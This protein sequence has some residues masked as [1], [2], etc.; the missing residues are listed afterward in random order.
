MSKILIV[1]DD[2]EL[3]DAL[4]DTLSLLNYTTST[5]SNCKQAL[6]ILEEEDIDLVISDIQMK[7]MD[8]I[9]LLKQI[10]QTY[11]NTP[12]IMMTAY[13]TIK[14]AVDVLHLGALDYLVKPFEP[15]VLISKVSELLPQQQI[16]S[17]FVAV[18]E[19]TNEVLKVARK[20]SD[21]DAN[22]LV[23]GPS[24]AGK[25]VL[26]QY[27][28]QHSA[29]KENPF[30]AINCAAIPDNMLEAILFGYCKGAFT[31]AYKSSP[32]KFELAQGGTLLLDEISEMSLPLQAKILR[33]LQECE[34]ERLGE[35]KPITLDVRV[36][37]T[38]NRDLLGEVKEGRFR[39][40]LYYR[41]NVI[42]LTL[43]AL[44][45]RKNDIIPLAEFLLN[46][47]ALGSNVK[48]PVLTQS[49][50]N[51]LMAYHWPGNVREL[52]NIIQRA[53]IMHKNGEIE[54]EDILYEDIHDRV[55][56]IIEI[57]ELLPTENLK[58]K[59]KE[60]II[61]A[62]KKNQGSRK[63]TAKKLGI[64]PRTLRYKL[65]RMKEEGISIPATT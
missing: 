34:V 19:K 14:Q 2:L 62:L 20:I 3:Q 27:I 5:A 29:R 64:S 65:A 30:I 42:R 49:A 59:E 63:D 48:P 50:C 46:K 15:E 39:E 61:E 51:K 25:E 38:S 21:T 13:G 16:D 56:E 58:A 1:E 55:T 23:T 22:V 18:D 53:F 24:G 41:L 31:G 28:H 8:G 12:I 9:E 57:E 10:N 43:P 45:D 54:A 37:A 4:T 32:G 11:S 40:D 17:G 7:G 35:H 44:A 52:E 33:V 6:S 47:V 36:I 26:V 60:I